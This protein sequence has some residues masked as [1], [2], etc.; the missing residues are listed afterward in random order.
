M[1]LTPKRRQLFKGT[2]NCNGRMKK[3]GEHSSLHLCLLDEV[4]VVMV[5]LLLFGL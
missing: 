4:E 3:K 2:Q 1:P 5:L